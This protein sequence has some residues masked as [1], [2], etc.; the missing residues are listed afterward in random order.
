MRLEGEEIRRTQ[1][2]LTNNKPTGI[3]VLDKRLNGGLPEGSLVCVYADPIS[4]PEAFLYQFASVRTTYYFNTSR[5]P[6]FIR[7]NMLA[8]GFEPDVVFVDVFSHYYLNEYGQFVVEDRYRD[9]EIFDFVDHQ[10]NNIQEGLFVEEMETP[11]S[12]FNGFTKLTKTKRDERKTIKS[13]EFNVIFD[14]I[15]FF[16][17]LDVSRGLKEWLL[18]KLYILSKQTKNLFYIYLMKNVQP[19]DLTYMVLDIC[20][21]VFD[22][23]TEK[24]GD[25]VSSRLAI[26]KIRNMPPITE[27]FRF[28]ISEGVQIDTSK[29][30]A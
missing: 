2:L 12:A 5:P 11:S 14:S 19:L 7:Q 18:N 9:K 24:I 10:L 8:M 30:I 3:M 17:N 13:K 28:Y 27:T 29:D 4:M 21:V 6:E 22:I 25:R 20:D 16:L 1:L 15:S 23:E 26:P